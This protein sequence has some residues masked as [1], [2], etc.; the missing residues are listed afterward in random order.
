M[1]RGDVKVRKFRYLPGKE[2]SCLAWLS[3]VPDAGLQPSAFIYTT[4]F[5]T[6]PEPSASLSQPTAEKKLL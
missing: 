6:N 2:K 5:L 1:G 3:E 4:Y